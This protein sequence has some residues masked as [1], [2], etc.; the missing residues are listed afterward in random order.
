MGVLAGAALILALVSVILAAVASQGSAVKMIA[1]GPQYRDASLLAASVAN[2][3]LIWSRRLAVA[4]IPLYLGALGVMSYSPLESQKAPSV[5]LTDKSGSKYCGTQLKRAG[6]ELLLYR[7]NENV[8]RIKLDDLGS[9]T[10]VSSCDKL[11][12]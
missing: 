2:K 11:Q 10:S 1:S 8:I 7:E 12:K 9:V 5:Q 3:R 4:I 6:R